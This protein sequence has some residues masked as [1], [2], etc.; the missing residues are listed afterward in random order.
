MAWAEPTAQ[1]QS[2]EQKNMTVTGEGNPPS[3]EIARLADG[4]AP[5][6]GAHAQHDE[7][8]GFLDARVVRLR[9]A[10]ALPVDLA[11]LVD[12]ALRAMAYE[13]GLAAPLDHRV[14]A[15]RNARQL[16]L[17]LREREHVRG[18]GHRPEELCHARL[19][20]GC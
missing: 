15:L 10:Q 9:V 11:R 7:P 5:Q 16:H 13:H 17:D 4:H 20:H 18:R 3:S 8:L 14:L 6:V 12:L 1:R 19:G 2:G